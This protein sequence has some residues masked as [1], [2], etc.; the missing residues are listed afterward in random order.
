MTRI[1]NFVRQA[2]SHSD[3][4]SCIDP[5]LER[6]WHLALRLQGNPADAE[7]LLQ[8]LLRR[9][10]RHRTELL[11]REAPGAWLAKVLYRLH[12]DRWRRRQPV[13][14]LSLDDPASPIALPTDN[15]QAEAILA[16]ITHA[17]LMSVM[18]TL[19]E[20]QRTVLLMHDAEGYTLDEIGHIQDV[21]V[22]TLKSRL[23][24]ARTAVRN[25]FK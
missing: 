2:G 15:A 3:F 20:A 25:K 5:H 23:H 6:L 19:P 9:A 24:R 17:E 16:G 18:M 13:A 4:E 11:S 1:I 7:D 22:G 8:D 12:V 10:W 14:E 21:P